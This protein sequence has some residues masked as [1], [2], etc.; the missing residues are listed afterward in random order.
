MELTGCC[1][2]LSQFPL[3]VLWAEAQEIP[4]RPELT[5]GFLSLLLPAGFYIG[6]HIFITQSPCFCIQCSSLN[7]SLCLISSKSAL[8]WG[9]NPVLCLIW[10]EVLQWLLGTFIGV[11]CSI[12]LFPWFS[13]SGFCSWFFR[14]QDMCNPNTAIL[15]DFLATSTS[16]SWIINSLEQGLILCMQNDLIQFGLSCGR[17]EFGLQE[18]KWKEVLGHAGRG[19]IIMD[20]SGLSVSYGYTS[21]TVLFILD[22]Q[23]SCSEGPALK[24]G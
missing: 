8:R 4:T 20:V 14:M 22:L 7:Q 13:A 9:T 23:R 6:C 19:G 1:V 5:S 10:Y 11:Y 15:S 24:T 12:P 17:I 18:Q 16:A 3:R 2:M 21:I